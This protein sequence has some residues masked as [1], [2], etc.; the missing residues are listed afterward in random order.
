MQQLPYLPEIMTL[1]PDNATATRG[2]GVKGA[3]LAVLSLPYQSQ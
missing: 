2:Q 1:D 3:N